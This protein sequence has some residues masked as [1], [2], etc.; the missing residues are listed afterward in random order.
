MAEGRPRISVVI[1][2][3][4]DRDYIGR[5]LDMLTR[6]TIGDVELLSLDDRSTD[7]TAEIIA[8]FPQVRRIT[9]APTPYVPGKVLN[10][11]VKQASGEIVVFNNS[12]A[13]PQSHDYLE[14]LIA[15]LA[16]P[17]VGAVYGQQICRPDAHI[18]VR[19]DYERAFGDG[20]IAATWRHF[21][22]LASSAIRMQTLKD[23]PFN[24]DICASE[25]IELSYRLRKQGFRIVYEPSAVTEHSHNYTFSGMSRRYYI[26]GLAHPYIFGDSVSFAAAC[27]GFAAEVARDY[28]YLFRHKNVSAFFSSPV[29]RFIQ[30]WRYY[31]GCRE[32]M[33]K[34]REAKKS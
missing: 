33:R 12:D 1:R 8:S 20:K 19:K 27:R 4:N 29:C 31:Q 17:A 15:P 24:E 23:N 13:I 3:H 32:S 14:K 21:F 18:L 2:S 7:G 30:R 11:A 6:Q 26:E 34:I 5:T 25:D 10:F 9:G 16:D 22:S 28:I